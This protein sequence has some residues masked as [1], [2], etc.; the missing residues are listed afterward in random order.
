MWDVFSLFLFALSIR[1]VVLAT[2]NNGL[3]YKL[4]RS[5][6]AV[7]FFDNF[8]FDTNFTVSGEVINDPTHGFVEYVDEKTAVEL[9][10]VKATE[11]EKLYIGVN[12]NTTEVTAENPP[13]SIR[14]HSKFTI[15]G[16]HLVV[17][18]LDHMP[19]TI[20]VNEDAESAGCGL[21][22]AF[23]LKGYEPPTWPENGEIDII[24][25]ANNLKEDQCTL[26]TSYGCFQDTSNVDFNGYWATGSDCDLGSAGV[27]ATLGCGIVSPPSP[28]GASFNT[29][30]A[31]RKKD[32]ISEVQRKG[33]QGQNERGGVYVTEFNR[34]KEIRVFYFSR[35]DIPSDL[36]AGTPVPDNWGT[37]SAHFYV[38]ADESQ[39]ASD[40]GYFNDMQIILNT[41][42]CGDWAGSAFSSNCPTLVADTGL[43]SCEDYIAKHISDLSEAYWLINKIDI[44]VQDLS[45]Y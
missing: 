22:P 45:H 4:L 44:Y 27:N 30:A 15:D 16:H 41:D 6:D 36:L 32:S 39:C 31:S 29:L 19:S 18:D 1:T 23:W 3:T 12:Y 9:G 26:H 38:G 33:E 5:T 20:P 8:D 24:E 13:K 42:I 10:M 11:D 28:V 25:Y 14:V 43:S 7:N 34:N 21:W 17:I 2:S 40:D 37:P 35:G